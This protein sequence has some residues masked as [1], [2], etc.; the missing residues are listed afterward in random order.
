[1]ESGSGPEEC[2]YKC[3]EEPGCQGFTHLKTLCYL[4]TCKN[5]TPDTTRTL[6]GATSGYK[7]VDR[8][9]SCC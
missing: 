5:I 1:M 4:K 3:N 8:S 9:S 2:C 7:K 6:S